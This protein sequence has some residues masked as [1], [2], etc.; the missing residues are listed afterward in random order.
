MEIDSN[1][2]WQSHHF[3]TP[4][5]LLSA[6]HRA[7]NASSQTY[8]DSHFGGAQPP[9]AA[10]YMKHLRQREGTYGMALNAHQHQP[11]DA[12][13]QYTEPCGEHN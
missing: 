8:Q 11:T 2:P 3:L 13:W 4:S 10:D 5:V 9:S 6:A 12:Q 7:A 1:S